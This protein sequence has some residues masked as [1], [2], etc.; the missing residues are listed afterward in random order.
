MVH[1]GADHASAPGPLRPVGRRGLPDGAVA[2]QLGVSL[3]SAMGLM[4]R[5]VEKGL[6][7]LTDEEMERARK[8]LQALVRG[9][10]RRP[11]EV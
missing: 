3:S 2:V 11:A 8:G 6:A 9:V 4:D 10:A 5:L 1:A 7:A